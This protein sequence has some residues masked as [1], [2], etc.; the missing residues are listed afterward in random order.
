MFGNTFVLAK[1]VN[2]LDARETATIKRG[3]MFFRHIT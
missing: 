3:V 1:N 2:P